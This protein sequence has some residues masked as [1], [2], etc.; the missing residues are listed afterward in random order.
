MSSLLGFRY[1]SRSW[2]KRP[3]P[4]AQVSK[5]LDT[6]V[7]MMQGQGVRAVCYL[8]KITARD[9][10][11]SFEEQ[12]IEVKFHKYVS[13]E[14]SHNLALVQGLEEGVLLS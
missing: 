8:R 4:R 6:N 10:Q 2:Q 9:P 7:C 13:I 1:V 5:G 3:P 11:G 14:N 12:F